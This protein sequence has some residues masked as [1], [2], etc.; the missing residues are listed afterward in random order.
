M[1]RRIIQIMAL[2]AALAVFSCLAACGT[3][4]RGTIATA[5]PTDSATPSPTPAEQIAEFSI[6]EV[7]ENIYT[8]KFIGMGCNFDSTWY[9]YSEAEIKDLNSAVLENIGDDLT[10]QLEKADYFY[11]MMASKLDGSASINIVFEKLGIGA[12]LTIDL[13]ASLRHGME[14]SKTGYANMGYTDFNYEIGKTLF[15]GKEYN[16][17]TYTANYTGVPVYGKQIIFVKGNY[18]VAITVTTFVNNTCDSVL[19]NFYELT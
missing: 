8:N 19:A 12:A 3:E 10:K 18:S 1:K 9:I 17:A 15:I 13:E 6:G 2:I 4:P 14:D 16:S 11:D 5:D 7:A